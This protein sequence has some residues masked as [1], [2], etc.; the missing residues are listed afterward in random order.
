MLRNNDYHHTF[1]VNIYSQDAKPHTTLIV[2][3]YTVHTVTYIIL[4]SIQVT[5]WICSN[6]YISRICFE[7]HGTHKQHTSFK[8]MRNACDKHVT[9]TWHLCLCVNVCVCVTTCSHMCHQWFTLVWRSTLNS[10]HFS[11][12]HKYTRVRDLS[13]TRPVEKSISSFTHGWKKEKT[14]CLL[15]W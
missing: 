3:L 6:S 13:I 8:Q 10:Q 4:K 7:H 5:I 1:N 12:A 2:N 9:I 14:V 15:N 11:N